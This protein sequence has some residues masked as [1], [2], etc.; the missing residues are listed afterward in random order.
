MDDQDGIAAAVQAGAFDYLTKPVEMDEARAVVESAL[1]KRA[2]MVRLRGRWQGRGGPVPAEALSSEKDDHEEADPE[3]EPAGIPVFV[4]E[5]KVVNVPP[6][7]DVKA[8]AAPP[9]SPSLMGKLAR[10][11]GLKQDA[12]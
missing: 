10:L 8:A 2:E 11:L 1:E 7:E 9:A 3:Q 4:E 5:N 12:A 6:P